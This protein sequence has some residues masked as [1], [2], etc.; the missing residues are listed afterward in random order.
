MKRIIIVN[1]Q[2]PFIRGGAE[3]QA[4]N[5]QKALTESGNNVELVRI[6]FIWYPP[7][8]ISKQILACRLLNLSES[9][10]EKIDLLIGLKFPTYYIRHPNKVLW[11]IHQH[12]RT[13]DLWDTKY[14]D[15]Q[16]KTE[17][18]KIKN[19][20][21]QSDN[22][23][24]PEA[25]KIFTISQNV[26][27]RLKKFNDLDSTPLYPPVKNKEN[28]F[29]AGFG[30]YIFFPSRISR[31]KRQELAIESM[32]Y[33]KRNVKM[34]IAGWPDSKYNIIKLNNLISKFHLN[35]KVEILQNITEDEKIN[36]YANSLAVLFIPY[37][38]DYGYVTL[39]AMY[40]KKPVI[41][42]KDS[43]GPL[44]FVEDNLTGYIREPVPQEIADAIDSLYLEKEKAKRLGQAGYEKINSMDISWK[45]VVEV[46][47]G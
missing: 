26:S 4:E 2:I 11:I 16:N 23:F 33:V 35:D 29:S 40:S 22:K 14:C 6:P 17:G 9:Y 34:I 32:K 27:N 38:E 45:R 46:L 43:G 31:I 42:C 20:I 21:T 7:E 10:G 3:I 1:T 39:E 12:R 25:K 30:E 18:L 13:Y 15:I 47:T 19:L 28:F 36:L 24:L 44:E 5:L 8:K 41:T 37:D